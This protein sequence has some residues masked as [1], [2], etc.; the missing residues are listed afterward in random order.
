MAACAQE[1]SRAPWRRGTTMW[2]LQAP[3]PEALAGI[4]LQFSLMLTLEVRCHR[5]AV[6][7]SAA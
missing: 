2:H 7:D 1:G 5:I 3:C 6:I 4:S